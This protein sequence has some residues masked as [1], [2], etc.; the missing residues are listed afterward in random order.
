MI[1][2]LR[3]ALEDAYRARATC[4]KI[5]KTFGPVPPFVTIKQA[6]ER[7]ARALRAVLERCGFEAPHDTWPARV[8]AP[9]TVAEACAAAARA[10]LERKA[11]YE[12]LIPLVRD[13][14][15]RRIMRRIQEASYARHLPALRRC[16]ARALKPTGRPRG[17]RLGRS[18]T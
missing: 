11:M 2:A 18:G 5:I 9:E 16:F 13:P 1:D 10:E 6:E 3:E 15:A 14:A 4:E 12:H 7:H 8:S 17:V